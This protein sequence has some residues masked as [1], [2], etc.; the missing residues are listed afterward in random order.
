MVASGCAGAVGTIDV[1]VA[2]QAGWVHGWIDF[3]NDGM[4]SD[5]EEVVHHYQYSGTVQYDYLIPEEAVAGSRAVRFRVCSSELSSP[6]GPAPDGEVEDSLFEVQPPVSVLGSV[7]YDKNN[8]AIND[9]GDP[10][11]RGRLVFAD[12]DDDGE[13]DTGWIYENDGYDSTFKQYWDLSRSTYVNLGGEPVT[14]VRVTLFTSGSPVS[15]MTVGLRSPSGNLVKL[16]EPT[17]G[18]SST[19]LSGTVFTDKAGIP[20][21]AGTPPYS[22]EF[23]PVEPL[24]EFVGETQSGS[25]TLEIVSSSEEYGVFHGWTL[26]LETLNRQSEPAFTTGAGGA[27]E[28][29]IAYTG[30]V[31]VVLANPPE[32]WDQTLPAGGDP[33]YSLNVTSGANVVGIDFGY[34]ADLDYGDASSDYPVLFAEDGACHV[35]VGP[36]MGNERDSEPDGPA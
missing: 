14:G 16:L 17:N 24:S 27:Y 10:G 9:F 22:G 33:S 30:E 28:L 3:N 18:V 29:S 36:Y 21:S 19:F 7:F 25:W 6:V 20:I 5:D 34:T 2:R 8:N 4:W 13:R 12:L 35:A 26:E 23:L 31:D 32:G 11:V 1:T 15:E